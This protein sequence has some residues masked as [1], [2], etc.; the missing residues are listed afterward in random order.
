MW[1][2]M[3]RYQKIQH[4]EDSLLRSEQRPSNEGP[5]GGVAIGEKQKTLGQYKQLISWWCGFGHTTG[6]HVILVLFIVNERRDN[7]FKWHGCELHAWHQ[8]CSL[9]SQP[10]AKGRAQ[11]E[12]FI[13][14]CHH[15]QQLVSILPD[16]LEATRRL[17]Q[18]YRASLP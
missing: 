15:R 3:S 2:N 14:G 5:Q 1:H 9:C 17:G 7:Y 18:A 11:H 13:L 12:W 6:L 8:M 4:M 10:V 16:S